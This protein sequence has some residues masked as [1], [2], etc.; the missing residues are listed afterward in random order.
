MVK[1][2]NLGTLAKFELKD[3][4][5]FASSRGEVEYFPASG[6]IWARDATAGEKAENEERK[7]DGLEKSKVQGETNFV[8]SKTT[9]ESLSN[10]AHELLKKTELLEEYASFDGVV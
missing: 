2:L 6:S 7:W 5:M 9:T 8:L 3:S 4:V 1:I 10:Q